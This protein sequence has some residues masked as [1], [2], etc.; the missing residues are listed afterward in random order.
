MFRY[1]AT[2]VVPAPRSELTGVLSMDVQSEPMLADLRLTL[3]QALEGFSPRKA[4]EDVR[5]RATPVRLSITPPA[6]QSNW[7]GQGGADAEEGTG[8]QP[9]SP[10][11]EVVPAGERAALLEQIGV[12]L[13]SVESLH[14]ALRDERAHSA[15]LEEEIARL[16]SE[17]A[18]AAVHCSGCA[19]DS[20]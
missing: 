13:S 19:C 11:T 8:T 2:R 15:F 17:R 6:W 4:D 12:L 7:V 20:R 5:S 18:N 1:S 14:T 10:P 9:S 16:R 3:E